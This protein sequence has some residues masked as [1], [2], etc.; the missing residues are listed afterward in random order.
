MVTLFPVAFGPSCSNVVMT[1]IFNSQ[2][3]FRSRPSL[4][5][6]TNKSGCN[7]KFSCRDF[8]CGSVSCCNLKL[9]VVTFN[10]VSCRDLNSTSLPQI[11]SFI[12]ELVAT[13]NFLTGTSFVAHQRINFMTSDWRHDLSCLQLV[14]QP[15]CGV[16]T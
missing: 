14:S 8:I 11:E 16:V 15:Q 10:P 3:F 5:S 4:R 1:W 12:L 7:F 9:H 2:C 6:L 13:S